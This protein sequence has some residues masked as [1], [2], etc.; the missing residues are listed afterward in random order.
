MKRHAIRWGRTNIDVKKGHLHNEGKNEPVLPW[1]KTSRFVAVFPL[2]NRPSKG[3][4]KTSDF[5]HP[6]GWGNAQLYLSGAMGKKP[7]KAIVPIVHALSCYCF[8]VNSFTS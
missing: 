1:R 7:R 4:R 3:W 5:R 8:A 2:Q 6:K